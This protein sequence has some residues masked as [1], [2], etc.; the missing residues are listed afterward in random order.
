MVKGEISELEQYNDLDETTFAEYDRV[1]LLPSVDVFKNIV[2]NN[3]KNSIINNTSASLI[4]FDIDNFKHVNDSFG[5][6]FG[7]SM[8]RIISSEVRNSINREVL[9]CR[10]SG[11][12]FILFQ[13]SESEN[14][15]EKTIEEIF[16]VFKQSHEDIYLTIS[17]GISVVP[18]DGISYD[19]LLKNADIA[20]YEAKQN[21]K[22]NYKFFSNEMGNKV[23]KEYALQKELRTSLENN[24]IYV[25]YQPKV[26]LEDST[27]QGF[28]ALARWNN[29]KFGEISPGKFIPLAEES[30]MIVPIGS[31]VLEEACRKIKFLS[32][33]GYTDFK[34]AVNLS[35]VQFQEEIVINVLRKLIKKY[36]ISSRHLELEI[37]ESMFMKSFESNLKVLEEIKDMGIT[38]ALDDFGTGYSSFS[39]L[40]KLPIDV[41]KIDRSFIL[42]VCTNPKEKCM[43]EGI[44]RLAHQLGIQVVAE[45]VEEEE[46][47]EYLKAIFCDFVQGY[48]FS[49]PK[50]FNEIIDIVG[51][52]Y[53][54]C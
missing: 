17:M 53:K 30:K 21:G 40:T 28:E 26:S 54:K 45:G 31:F 3:I 6:E 19:F 14:E 13:N 51:K 11:N 37:T 1:T 10:Y 44:I 35:E 50:P 15:I 43:V 20:M 25:V 8:L 32:S 4:L 36:Q 39:Y 46:Q 2:K 47:V 34:I 29:K 16:N 18:K 5:H 12:T 27:V 24:E 33:K 49:R 23:V 9:I 38:I 48:Y 42:D 7:D 41:L 52:K 22:N